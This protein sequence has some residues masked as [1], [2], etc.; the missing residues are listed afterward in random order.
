M[1]AEYKS[2]IESTK[3]TPYLALAGEQWCA[4]RKNFG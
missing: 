4:F 3:D 2:E 1:G